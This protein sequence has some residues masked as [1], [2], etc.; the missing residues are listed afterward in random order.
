VL[1]LLPTA[2]PELIKV[3]FYCL[4]KLYHPDRGGDLAR[5]QAVNSAWEKLRR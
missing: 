4:A 1:H 2:P 5:M 3:A